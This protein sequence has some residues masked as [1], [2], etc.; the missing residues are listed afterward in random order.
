MSQTWVKLTKASTGNYIY[1]NMDKVTDTSEIDGV[2]YISFSGEDIATVKET[3][4]QILDAIGG[5]IHVPKA[6][7]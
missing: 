6:D 3:P 5:T 4:E 1:V 2:T 7:V